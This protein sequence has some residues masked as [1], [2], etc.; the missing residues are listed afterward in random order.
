MVHS[1]ISKTRLIQLQKQ[2]STQWWICEE[3]Y[4]LLYLTG[5]KL[6]KGTL[7][8][9]PKIALFV[10][11]R[12]MEAAR[13]AFPFE[14]LPLERLIPWCEQE[15]AQQPV[16]F[17]GLQMSVERHA[18]LSKHML[19]ESCCNPIR[20]LRMVKSEEEI[21]ALR[22]SAALLMK[23]F[24]YL[25]SLL[26]EGVVE[27]DLAKAFEIYALENGAE[28]MS[29]EPIVAFGPHSAMPHYRAGEGILKKGDVVLIDVGV[30]ACDYA[31]DMTRTL[32]FGKVSEEMEKAYRVAFEA[33]QE[34]VK[35]LRVGISVQELD[36]VYR[37]HLS[38]HGNYAA[39]HSVGHSL[40]LEVHEYPRLSIQ[41]P[42]DVVLQKHMV[43]TVEPGIYIPGVGGVRYED[44][45]LLEES[46]AYNFY[47]ELQIDRERA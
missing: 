34:V 17:D 47:H 4:D 19:L 31:S 20:L 16:G 18:V 2:L 6:S 29:F 32:F 13:K 37:H 45:F 8:I 39:L 5:V 7:L 40:G 41:T 27:K 30:I 15:I 42:E 23:S 22:H 3:Y 46:G 35:K 43:V 21:K 44:M 36:K 26:K 38:S 9:G 1:L 10:D 12:Y 11:G 14:V 33:Y 25:L 28:K 24:T